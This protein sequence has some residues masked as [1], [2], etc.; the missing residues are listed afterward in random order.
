MAI[1]MVYN[2]RA[3][4]TPVMQLHSEAFTKPFVRRPLY[5]SECAFN[6]VERL[7]KGFFFVR[8]LATRLIDFSEKLFDAGHH[9]YRV[10]VCAWL[11]GQDDAESRPSAAGVTSQLVEWILGQPFHVRSARGR[12]GA[13]LWG[14][15]T[16]TDLTAGHINAPAARMNSAVL[17]RAYAD[18]L[19]PILTGWFG[20]CCPPNLATTL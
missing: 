17:R 5:V 14:V 12:S 20:V 16:P 15:D 2:F 4:S 3:D 13:L 1:A 6:G 7:I 9:A 19:E 10:T 18:I 8:D 11:N